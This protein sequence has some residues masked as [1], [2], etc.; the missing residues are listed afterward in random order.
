MSSSAIAAT[1]AA[2]G[3]EAVASSARVLSVDVLRGFDM[4]WIA[5]SYGLG[6]ALADISKTGPVGFVATQLKHVQ[7]EGFR[8][9]DLI[10]PLFLF[11]VGVSLVF[12]LDRIL[13]RE[14]RRAAFERIVRRGIILFLLGVFYDGGVAR[15]HDSNLIC[16]VLQRLALGYLFTG[17]LYCVLKP[18]GLVITFVVLLVSYWAL[19][20]FV[21]VPD[22]GQVSFEEG[23]NWAHYV[24]RVMPPYHRIDNEGYLSTFPAI[25]TCLLGVFAALLLKNPSIEARKKVVWFLAGGAAMTV[26]G[27]LWGLQFPI[28]K[29]AWTS[30]YVLVAGGYSLMLLG[31]CYLAID[32]RKWQRW[33]APF[34]WIGANA[35]TLYL[36]Q[37]ILPVR[38]VAER[39]VGGDIAQAAGRYGNLV[40]TL[41]AIGLSLAFMRFLY[42]KKIFLRV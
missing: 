38:R 17:L 5:G 15:M 24:D 13:A 35:I 7:W 42:K 33:A 21:P 4:F 29:R 23:K 22:T 26:L 6:S 16:G 3:T 34:I 19:W 27:Y 1:E 9:Y 36:G 32:V 28:I 31:L 10:F 20:T 39:F 41:A 37:T 14:G 30:S 25:A 12:S 11:I 18:K 40:I 8:F 2:G